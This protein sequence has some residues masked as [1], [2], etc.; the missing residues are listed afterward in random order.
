MFENSDDERDIDPKALQT[1]EQNTIVKELTQRSHEK[2]EVAQLLNDPGI[3][4]VTFFL[5]KN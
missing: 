3:D 5:L 1:A 2:W 4:N